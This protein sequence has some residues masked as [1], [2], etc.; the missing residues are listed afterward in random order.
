MRR[1][2]KLPVGAGE[3]RYCQKKRG[4]GDRKSYWR[5][6][7]G[8]RAG[9]FALVRGGKQRGA[10]KKEAGRGEKLPK[11]PKKKNRSGKKKNP[12]K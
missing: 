11:G 3:A 6:P 8:G 7:G 12:E 2:K 9:H 10:P 5:D 4:L 1:K